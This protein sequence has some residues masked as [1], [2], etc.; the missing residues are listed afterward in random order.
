MTGKKEVA[1]NYYLKETMEALHDGGLLL[2]SV[3]KDEENDVMTIG[4]G[5]VGIVW[6]FPMFLVMVRPSRLTYEF[7]EQTKQ[8]TVNVP[9]KAMSDAVLFCGKN[10]GRDVDKFE[11]CGFTVIP[12]RKVSSVGID[13]CP[14][15]YECQVIYHNDFEPVRIPDDV[16]QRVYAQGN[17]NRIYYGK[18]LGVYADESL[19]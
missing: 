1:Y 10:S 19:N 16:A 7:I 18:I 15:H 8:F 5:T 14:I 4:W 13:E 6:S 12:G 2:T 11:K 17:Y 3:R 9:T